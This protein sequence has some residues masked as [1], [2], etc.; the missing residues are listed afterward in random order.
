MSGLCLLSI[1][2]QVVLASDFGTTGVVCRKTKTPPFD[3]LTASLAAGFVL[4]TNY[5]LLTTH[6]F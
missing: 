1:K 3:L 5:Q 2:S 6:Y 4:T